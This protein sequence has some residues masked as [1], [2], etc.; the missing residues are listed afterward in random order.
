MSIYAKLQLN[1]PYG[2]APGQLKIME[3]IVP[4]CFS[5]G[6]GVKYPIVTDA[7]PFRFL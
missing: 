2:F 4:S 1:P 6:S 3:N 5:Y 7:A